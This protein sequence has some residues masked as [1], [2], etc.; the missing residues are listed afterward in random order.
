MET[1]TKSETQHKFPT[2]VLS[3]VCDTHHHI[4]VQNGNQLISEKKKKKN[5]C[6]IDVQ[7]RAFPLTQPITPEGSRTPIVHNE[8][9]ASWKITY[10]WTVNVAI[11]KLAI[12]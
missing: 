5:V 12:P 8:I 4:A 2:S 3:S 9:C 10:I 1:H 7:H 6:P 11:V